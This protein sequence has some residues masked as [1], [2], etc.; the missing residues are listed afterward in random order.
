MVLIF[1]TIDKKI[2][3]ILFGVS[4][5]I[6]KNLRLLILDDVEPYTES[7]NEE[8]IERATKV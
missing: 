1:S 8:Y 7:L 4:E 6:L 3:S 2:L 5:G